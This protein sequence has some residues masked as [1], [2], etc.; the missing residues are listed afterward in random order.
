MTNKRPGQCKVLHSLYEQV[1]HCEKQPYRNYFTYR[2]NYTCGKRHA[3]AS[4]LR[5]PI[6]YC[7]T[8]DSFNPLCLRYR[9]TVHSQIRLSS[10]STVV[11]NG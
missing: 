10:E 2:N 8:E 11:A 5:D 6:R 4:K 1:V 3:C 9:R 7:V